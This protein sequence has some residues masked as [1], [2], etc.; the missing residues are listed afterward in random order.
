MGAKFLLSFNLI[1]G[2]NFSLTKAL[3]FLYNY[4]PIIGMYEYYGTPR[5]LC[6]GLGLRFMTPNWDCYLVYSESICEKHRINKGMT[7]ESVL[8]GPVRNQS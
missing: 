7:A 8:D 1:A 5:V 3:F 2:S 6:L 4:K